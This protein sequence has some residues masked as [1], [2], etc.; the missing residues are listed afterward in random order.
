MSWHRIALRTELYSAW[1]P[2]P[3]P[4]SFLSVFC[5]H[6]CKQTGAMWWDARFCARKG[7]LKKKKGG[8]CSDL[9]LTRSLANNI[10]CI[11]HNR[12]SVVIC[13]NHVFSHTA[14]NYAAFCRSTQVPLLLN[15]TPTH[16]VNACTLVP[17]KMHHTA[18]PC[19]LVWCDLK[20]M[21]APFCLFHL[22]QPNTWEW[23]NKA[24]AP[25]G[26]N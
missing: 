17:A 4:L 7:D 21:S 8:V 6:P 10:L 2:P 11:V 13:K 1:L 26:V 23:P 22:E 19:I 9:Q 16:L 15:G 12:C 14:Q 3:S 18:V 24:H 25:P 20:K 5:I